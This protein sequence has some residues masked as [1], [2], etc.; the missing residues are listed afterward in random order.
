LKRREIN[1][2]ILTVDGKSSSG[3]ST[4]A[5]LLSRKFQIPHLSSGLLYRWGAKK[6]IDKKPKNKVSYLRKCFK[7][8]DYKNIKK[9]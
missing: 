4:A 6:I 7:R 5:K 3:K 1:N 2:F 8:F 9:G